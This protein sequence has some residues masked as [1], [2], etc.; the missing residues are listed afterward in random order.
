MCLFTH[1]QT[2]RESRDSKFQLDALRSVLM[3][4]R[5][6]GVIPHRLS[7]SPLSPQAPVSPFSRDTD[8]DTPLA[9]LLFPPGPTSPRSNP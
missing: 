8:K 2:A 7:Q 6:P 9:H 1:T 5:S 4:E 3:A